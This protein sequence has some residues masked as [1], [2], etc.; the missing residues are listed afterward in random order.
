MRPELGNGERSPARRHFVTDVGLRA[1]SAMVAR[2]FFDE[3]GN[4]GNN[5]IFRWFNGQI[6]QSPQQ[7]VHTAPAA[8]K[9]QRYSPQR[10]VRA[11]RALAELSALGTTPALPV[12]CSSRLT[13][14][15]GSD[16]ALPPRG[17]TNNACIYRRVVAG[18][19]RINADIYAGLPLEPS[20]NKVG[21]PWVAA[22]GL[23]K[24]SAL[25]VGLPAVRLQNDSALTW[26]A[27][28]NRF[29]LKVVCYESLALLES[30]ERTFRSSCYR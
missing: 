18:D 24:Q 9:A 21:I 15:A 25:R 1:S 27:A 29:R 13:N 22:A 17:L 8:M 2:R 28:G 30:H 10:L 5:N 16:C 7:S 11:A 14:N 3:A 23:A 20:R 26:V 12:E 4:T 19:L 6:T